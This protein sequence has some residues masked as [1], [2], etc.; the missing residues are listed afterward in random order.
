MRTGTAWLEEIDRQ[1]READFLVALL[2]QESA[3]SEMVQAEVQ[4]AFNYQKRQGHPHILPVRVSYRG[5]LPYTIDAFLNPLQYV[6]WSSPA[7]NERLGREILAAIDGEFPPQQAVASGWPTADETT[8]FTI[9]EDGQPMRDDMSAPLPEFDPRF[10]DDLS[11]PGGAV[12]LRDEFYVERKA[13]A[14]LRRQNE[15]RG[16]ITTILAPRQ[17]GKSSLLVRGVHH[18]R[19]QG[20]RVVMVDLQRVD[21]DDLQTIDSFLRYVAH[22]LAR[23]LRLPAGTVDRAWQQP[24]GTQ[25]KLTYLME[26][27]ILPGDKPL[28]LAIDEADRLLE[29]GYHTDVFGLIRAWH[30]SAAYDPL[31]ENLNIAMAISTEPYLLI[32]DPNQSPFNVGLKLELEDFTPEQVADLNQ[33]HRSPVATQDLPAL[34][35][36]LQGHPYLTRKALYFLVKESQTWAQLEQVAATDDD[37]VHRSVGK[38]VI[39]VG[40]IERTPPRFVHDPLVGTHSLE[41]TREELIGIKLDV[42]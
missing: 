15:R 18:T 26:D 25:D 11:V 19:E 16:S 7:D 9:S 40:R 42:G 1:I 24:W 13:D 32:A 35:S 2:S 30:N 39:E 38:E 6:S 10:L 22:S 41:F 12:R 4:R 17:T 3:D 23:R 33:R 14:D 8:P 34:M 31:W 20:N 36:L 28:L 37:R 21:R 5:L 29:T 27:L